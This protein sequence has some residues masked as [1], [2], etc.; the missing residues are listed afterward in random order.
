M[1]KITED[2]ERQIKD[3][4]GEALST[5]FESRFPGM[6]YEMG[7]SAALQWVLGETPVPPMEDD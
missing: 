7:V 4:L 3:Q 1:F 2:D 5:E 6:T